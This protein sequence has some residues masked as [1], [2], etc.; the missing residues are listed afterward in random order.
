MAG[1]SWDMDAEAALKKVPVLVRPL[2]RRKVEERVRSAGGGRVRLADYQEAEARFRAV[3]GGR[4]ERELESMLPTANRPGVPMVMVESCRNELA[5]CPNALIDTTA[6]RQAI[7]E[8]VAQA[9]LSE[10]LRRRLDGDQVLFHH[11]LRIAVAGCPNGCSRP[12]IADLAVVGTV[13]PRFDAE[14]CNT[15]GQCAAACPD[16]AIII[17]ETAWAEPALCQGCKACS[18][19]CEF[20][21]ITLGQPQ[22]QVLVGGK[23]GRHPHLAMQAG[24]AEDPAQAVAQMS[25]I[26]ESYLQEALPGERLAAWWV[27]TREGGR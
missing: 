2:A 25:P 7:A 12:Q 18:Q 3:R 13:Q 6:W 23:L 24:L 14:A 8:W 20:G 26:V 9:D 1:L 19:A 17:D 27:R 10:R 4:S 15:C 21:A 22:G 11:K 16:Q 5:N